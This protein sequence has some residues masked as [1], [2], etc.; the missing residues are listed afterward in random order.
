MILRGLTCLGVLSMGSV[1]WACCM[2]PTQYPGDV[3][4]TRQDVVILHHD[5]VE[6]L[7]IRVQ[8]TFPDLDYGPTHMAWLITIP[9]PASDYEVM[10]AEVFAEAQALFQRLESLAFQQMR[11]SAPGGQLSGDASRGELA[12]D[13]P[14][15]IGELVKIGPYE[16]TPVKARGAAA[17]EALNE[18]L[19]EREFPAESADELRWFTERE[20]TFLC[21]EVHPE[22]GQKT[23][24][25]NIELPALRVEFATDRPYYPGRYSARQGDFALALTVLTSEPLERASLRRNQSRLLGGSM[26]HNLYTVQQLPSPLRS[27]AGQLP[28]VSS[29][30]RWYV[31]ALPSW[32]FNSTRNGGPAI[33]AWDD[34]IFFD[35]GGAADL[36]PDW[37]YGDSSLGA[38]R[39]WL[40]N[41]LLVGSV[42]LALVAGFVFLRMR[43]RH[44]ARA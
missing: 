14:L 20:F 10:D 5:G 40:S 41:P 23:L 32:G 13:S 8:P 36:P 43:R 19:T 7:L 34:D 12:S 15:E 28:E 29:V 31:N 37:Y 21:I 35:I 33:Q 6:E 27:A 24:G 22:T 1:V 3:D 39:T 4:Q 11:E 30:D 26:F 18:Y 44:R 16:I 2:V 38:V 42:V 9:A 25:K 17:A